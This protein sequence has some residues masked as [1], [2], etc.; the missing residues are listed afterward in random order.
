M[1]VIEIII[2][3][4]DTK[5]DG[6]SNVE[7]NANKGKL[8]ITW[9]WPKNCDLV[10]IKKTSDI[11]LDFINQIFVNQMDESNLK[12]YTRDEYKEFGG[13]VE[14]IKDINQ[15]KYWIF[16]CFENEN[17]LI[18]L[19][20][21]DKKN[22]I[23]VST[24]KPQILYQIVESK[25]I[26]N[27]FAKEKKVQIVIE[28]ESNIKKDALYYVKKTGSF[29][30]NKDDGI[31]FNFLEDIYSG[32]NVMPEFSLGKDEYIKLFINEEFADKYVLKQI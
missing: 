28:C 21:N 29:P 30:I 2:K 3:E 25:G 1:G 10:Y 17:E 13:Y 23:T 16:P 22:E 9:K 24:G 4:F 18:L 15:Y 5:N 26:K 11:N 8:I 27:F 20:Q 12:L 19:K 14:N 6:V 32:K 31:K 7:Y